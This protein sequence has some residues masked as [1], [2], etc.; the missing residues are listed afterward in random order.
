MGYKPIVSETAQSLHGYAGDTRKQKAHVIIPRSQVGSASN[1]VGFEKI[2]GKYVMH[3]SEYDQH[4]FKTN[5]L[6]Q[7]YQ[8]SKITRYVKNTRKLSIRSSE[9]RKDGSIAIKVRIGV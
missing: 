2:K 4:G 8:K 9:V 6:K 3:L 7:L 1:D 5:K